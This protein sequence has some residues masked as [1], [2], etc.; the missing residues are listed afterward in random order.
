MSSS[1][2]FAYIYTPSDK[3]IIAASSSMAKFIN[4][5]NLERIIYSPES[6]IAATS[7]TN[8]AAHTVEASTVAEIFTKAIEI[9][10]KPSLIVT[11]P[12]MARLLVSIL[13]GDKN[14]VNKEADSNEIL[15]VAKTPSGIFNSLYLNIPSYNTINES[16]SVDD[17]N[18]VPL[19]K[20]LKKMDVVP[21]DPKVAPP[22][23]LEETKKKVKECIPNLPQVHRTNVGEP[24]LEYLDRPMAKIFFKSAMVQDAIAAVIQSGTHYQP[25]ATG[26]F[27]EITSDL[28]M[29]FLAKA[30]SGGVDGSLQIYP[31]IIRWTVEKGEIYT[32][33]IESTQSIGLKTSIV[34][35]PVAFADSGIAAYTALGHEVTGHDVLRANSGLFTELKEHIAQEIKPQWLS[36]YWT[37]VVDDG[38]SDIMGILSVGPMA[39]LG[40]VILF[41]GWFGGLRNYQPEGDTHPMDV[42]RGYLGAQ[43]IRLLKFSDRKMW[44]DK[45]ESKTDEILADQG[46]TI[47]F[48][49]RTVSWNQTPKTQDEIDVRASIQTFA[50]IITAC[51]MASLNNHALGELDN[52]E[53]SDEAIVDRI[54]RV[55]LQPNSNPDIA[56]PE[57]YYAAHAVAAATKESILG[58]KS[59][60]ELARIF[61]QMLTLLSNMNKTNPLFQ[62]QPYKRY[63]RY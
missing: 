49:D 11:E 42:L 8:S 32:W 62:K 20:Q 48:V 4:K 7:L 38:A 59:Q 57:G 40:L 44:A 54:R 63:F 46:N 33:P 26:A 5:A 21:L 41:E 61:T 29:S 34:G 14:V 36:A 22:N 6:Q 2:I 12:K 10:G 35:L 27:Q 60:Q 31:P 47:K 45:L 43:V 3:Q 13:C 18:Y 17:I 30:N 25:M 53:D 37:K 15:I 24:L 23:T 56:C 16:E 50:H 58:S 9:E 28:Y 55:F 19:T 52:W 39:G 1:S 51:Q